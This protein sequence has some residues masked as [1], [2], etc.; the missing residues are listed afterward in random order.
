MEQMDLFQTG[1]KRAGA[2]T[3]RPDIRP[4]FAEPVDVPRLTEQA[5]NVLARLERGP[6]QNVELAGEPTRYGMGGTKRITE[7]RAWLKANRRQTIRKKALLE[8]DGRHHGRWL[9]WIE[10]WG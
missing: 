8:S 5:R 7:V 3:E 4:H 1:A 6:V 10:P 2:R 9:Y